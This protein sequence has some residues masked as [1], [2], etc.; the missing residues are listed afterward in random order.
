MRFAQIPPLV[1]RMAVSLLREFL[2]DFSAATTFIVPL[3]F[4]MR[5]PVAPA[6]FPPL[7]NLLWYLFL[8]CHLLSEN[9]FRKNPPPYLAR[10]PL[11]WTKSY[12]SIA[13]R[14]LSAALFSRLMAIFPPDAFRFFQ[15][16]DVLVPVL[17]VEP[18]ATPARSSPSTPP[19]LLLFPNLTFFRV[20]V[21]KK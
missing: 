6:S 1:I 13:K 18:Y 15:M 5:H 20:T 7:L 12:M 8:I 4:K 10:R 2:P 19:L 3:F 21:S 11:I 16:C 14:R 9:S 17:V